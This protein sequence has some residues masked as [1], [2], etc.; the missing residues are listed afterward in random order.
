V[1]TPKIPI[2]ILSG[3]LGSGKTTLLRKLVHEVKDL[4]LGVIVNDM[5]DLEVDGDLVRD[6]EVFNEKR[7][8][9]RSIYA[10]SIS[11]TRR[12][13]FAEA[14]DDW[15]GRTDLDHIVVETSGSTH[16]WPLIQEICARPGY[17]LDTFVALIDA[18]S[19]IQDYD[20]GRQ[21]CDHAQ[22]QA[23]LMAAQIALANVILITKAEKLAPKAISEIAQHL[24][25]LNPSAALYTTSYGNIKPSLLLGTGRF[26]AAVAQTLAETWCS[27]E[28]DDSFSTDLGSTVIHDPRPLHP[29]RLHTLFNERLGVGIHRSKGFI[30]MPS[31]D[32]D[33][34]LWN[35]AAGSIEMELMAY[36]KA[37][38]VSNPDGKLL[39]EEITMLQAMLK[40]THPLFGDRACELTII[41]TAHDRLIFTQELES[42]FCTPEEITQWKQGRP[43]DDPWPKTLLSV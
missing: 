18:K 4:R 20:S 8:N 32:R 25:K 26:D 37:A 13:A 27:K 34:L 41:G 3:F 33:V 38:L 21:I 19:L 10:G 28:P 24:T 12:S 17:S 36:W 2:T 6:P 7:G 39:P 30:W 31:R 11:G 42:C 9:F 29:R 40:E 5:S 35:Q 16:P 15:S 22:P 1:S 43:F 23:P 14:L